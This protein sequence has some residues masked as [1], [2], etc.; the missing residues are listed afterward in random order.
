M[1]KFTFLFVFAFVANLILSSTAFGQILQRGTSTNG[2]STNASLQIS[3]PTGVVAGDVMIVNIAQRNN[4]VNAPTLAGWTAISSGAIDG[5]STMGAL[6]YRVADGTEGA[7]FTFTL[8]TGAN[9]NTGSIVAFSGVDVSGPTPFDVAPGSLSLSLATASSATATGITTATANAAVILFAQSSDNQPMST[10]NTTSPGGLTQLY[11]NEYNPSGSNDLTVGAAWAIKASA[12]VTGNGTVALGG[13]MRWGAMLV[14]LKAAPLP[15]PNLWAANGTGAIQKYTVNPVTGAI[16]VAPSN[17][18]IPSTSTAALAKNVIN[19]NDAEGCLYY[20]NRDDA[21]ALNGVVTVYSVRPDGTGNGS[22]GTIDM[23]GG[24]NDDFSFV[25]MGFD[26]TGRGWIL[27]G[28]GSN[29]YIA[30]FQGNGINPITSINTYGETSLTVAAPGVA[31]EFQNGDLA[32]S[33]NGVL[34]ALANVTNGQTYIYTLNSLATPTT[35]TRKWTVQTGGGT[36]SGSVNG[37]AWTQTG[38]LHF[39]TATGIYFIDQGT[40]STVSGTVQ[41]TLVPGSNSTTLTD[42]AS[43]KFPT[44][45]TLPVKLGTFTVTKQG[46]N[47]VIDWTTLTEANTNHFEIERSFDG[48]NF[49]TVGTKQASGSSTT[50]VSYQ[51]LD[52]ITTSARI[53]YYRLKTV[54]VDANNSLSKIVA[55]RLNGVLVSDFTV[56]PNPFTSDL[57][58]QISSEKETSITIRV[59]NAMG[60]PVVNR[61]VMLQSGENVLVLSSEVSKLQSG[62]YMLEIIS[63]E[64]KTTQK[65][66]KR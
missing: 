26:A 37:L 29:I 20:L 55:L 4:G 36:F 41:A 5:G 31:T 10:W 45:S 7:N 2:T 33:G 59:S 18:V 38:S 3:K 40:A 12:G 8:G 46:N 9:N 15:A 11:S 51:H 66:I 60:Q 62:M 17:V 6:L 64:G 57:K 19:A 14:A 47:A 43:D 32:I 58:I 61:Q 48:I 39:S 1:K 21:D 54:D 23:N 25:R 28:S 50:V 56:Y 52:P 49:T 27:A 24:L 16:V 34:Y 44:Q 35:L 42:L 63:A 22:R 65:I 53:I 13:T 30:S